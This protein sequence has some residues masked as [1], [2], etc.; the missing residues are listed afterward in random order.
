MEKINNVILE[1]FKDK[2]IDVNTQIISSDTLRD[3]TENVDKILE[4]INNQ[5]TNIIIGTEII[6]KGY[7]FSNINLVVIL[8]FNSLLIEEGDIRANERIF[9]LITQVSGR[10][11]REKENG[12]I[13]IQIDKES[14]VL[15]YIQNYDQDG[16]YNFEIESRKKFNLPP[17]IKFIAI[18]ISEATKEEGVAI[19]REFDALFKKYLKNLEEKFIAEGKLQKNENIES[20]IK[21]LGPSESFMHFL[22]RCYRYRFLIK[23]KD[24]NYL[25]EVKKILQIINL[26][27]KKKIKIDIDP[28][29]FV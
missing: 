14:Q 10:A 12:K 5:N 20:C 24:K 2:N 22:K 18:I 8:D 19:A 26:K 15:E 23:I 11:G 1:F 3:E 6:S 27:L 4:N 29:N 13:F 25:N 16:F 17:F 9:Q 21:I 28:Y 7:H